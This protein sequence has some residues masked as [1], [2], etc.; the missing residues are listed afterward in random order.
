MGQ[1]ATAQDINDEE[2]FGGHGPYRFDDSRNDFRFYLH[3]DVAYYSLTELIARQGISQWYFGSG[4]TV[5]FHTISGLSAIGYLVQER[6][7]RTLDFVVWPHENL[8]PDGFEDRPC[9]KLSSN[10]RMSW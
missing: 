6:E 5:G 4:G 10:L 2:R 9:R 7:A 8:S 1:L 3:N